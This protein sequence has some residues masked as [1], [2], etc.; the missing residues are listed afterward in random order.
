MQASPL[1]A[2]AQNWEASIGGKNINPIQRM[3]KSTTKTRLNM[4]RPVLEL[5]T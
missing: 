1:L 2:K 4:K 5:K 3:E